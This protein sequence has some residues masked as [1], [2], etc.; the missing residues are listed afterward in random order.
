[1]PILDP[2]A[3]LNFV[4]TT[5]RAQIDIAT[6]V[7]DSTDLEIVLYDPSFRR[8]RHTT[9]RT[10]RVELDARDR[11]AV[12]SRGSQEYLTLAEY[13]AII[14]EI[15]PDEFVV[16]PT[17]VVLK[18]RSRPTRRPTSPLVVLTPQTSET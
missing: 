16:T 6:R 9:I 4:R 18:A 3:L 10:Y 1:M 8:T 14:S 13:S 17:T 15:I 11:Y 12:L 7:R 5:I 2:T